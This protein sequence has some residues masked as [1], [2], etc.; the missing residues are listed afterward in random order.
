MEMLRTGYEKQSFDGIDNILSSPIVPQEVKT[1][2]EDLQLTHGLHGMADFMQVDFSRLTWYDASKDDVAAEV[3]SHTKDPE[4]LQSD[5]YIGEYYSRFGIGDMG[6]IGRLY[7][8][9]EY[10]FYGGRGTIES[11]K[12]A[13]IYQ[14]NL[15]RWLS[16]DL[17]GAK[18][19]NYKSNEAEENEL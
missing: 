17:D 15:L 13:K 9:T 5:N 2:F 19:R 12:T 1:L 6:H 10:K 16:K 7:L 3:Q 11:Q 18:Q 14:E 4:Y 8:Q